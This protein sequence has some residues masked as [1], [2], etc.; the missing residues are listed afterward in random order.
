[1]RTAY[2]AMEL[3]GWYVIVPLSFASLLTGI[4]Q[5]LGTPWGLFQH[6]WI[7]AKL[8]I[9]ILATVLL[10]VHMRPI[11][12]VADVASKTALSS[13][14]LHGSRIQLVADASAA[15]LAL[16]AATA[17]SVYKPQGRTR[18]GHN[19]YE[20]RVGSAQRLTIGAPRWVFLFGIIA[21]VFLII[22][23]HLTLGPGGHSH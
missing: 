2:L 22:V 4:V 14:D 6:Y 16:L 12:H 13:A 17:L 21:A 5:A 8:A 18:Y 20:Q 9:S 23:R 3:T 11:V 7:L 15:L 1:M 19:K 10:M